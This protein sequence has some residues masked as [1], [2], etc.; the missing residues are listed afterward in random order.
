M[1]H[2]EK[3]PQCGSRKVLLRTVQD[4]IGDFVGTD[5]IAEATR[6]GEPQLLYAR[7]HDCGYELKEPHLL[8]DLRYGTT[9]R[10]TLL[11]QKK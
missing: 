2:Y 8:V 11:S 10:R 7:C 1:K 4:F 3:C 6:Q 5:M 9:V